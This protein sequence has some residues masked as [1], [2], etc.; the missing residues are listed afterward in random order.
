MQFNLCDISCKC[1]YV[2]IKCIKGKEYSSWNRFVKFSQ[3]MFFPTYL[4]SVYCVC[5]TA[6]EVLNKLATKIHI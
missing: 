4:H 3:D 6:A 5:S 2:T 1:L